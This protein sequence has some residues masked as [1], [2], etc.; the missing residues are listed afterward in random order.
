[1]NKIYN[2]ECLEIMSTLPMV[3]LTWFFVIYPMEQPKMSGLTPFDK[4]WAQ[5]NRVVENGAIVLTAQPP[6]DKI[7]ACLILKI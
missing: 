2:G 7:L 1:M 4:L 5:Y 6:F 3:V